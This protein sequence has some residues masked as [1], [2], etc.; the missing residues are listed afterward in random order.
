MAR[1]ADNIA[2]L[3]AM[4]V[5]AA[6]ATRRAARAGFDLG[7]NG[8]LTDRHGCPPQPNRCPTSSRARS[9]FCAC[10]CRRASAPIS[11]WCRWCGLSGVI[12][13][14]TPLRPGLMLSTIARSLE[15][16]FA[17]R[18]ARAVALIINSPGGSPAQSHLIFRRIRQ[19]A[20]GKENS[21]ARLRRGCRRLR[22]LHAGLRRRRD[23]LRS[24]FD[25]RLDRRGR[26]LVRL[27]QADGKARHRAPALHRRASAR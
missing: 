6:P 1:I 16:A 15:R 12:G 24:I 8:C 22:R 11:R 20:A 21:G 17:I 5:T 19:L 27:S 9:I 13:V 18:N 3:H 2:A 4:T 23:H 10:C 7:S 25:R 26:R 14:S